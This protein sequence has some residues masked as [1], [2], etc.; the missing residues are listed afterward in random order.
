M[1]NK[2]LI[3]AGILLLINFSAC[4][5]KVENAEPSGWD[6]VETI[7]NQI[8]EPV[9]QDNNF[10]LLDFG[11]IGD[12][13]FD[14]IQAFHEIIEHCT[15]NG[16][17]K[18]IV[19]EGNYF[20]KGP[21]HLESNINLHLE[22]GARL[23]F[24]SDP[25]DY[26]PNVLTS[27]EGTRIYNYSPF[28][29]AINKKNII[30]SGKGEIDGEAAETWSAW[31]KIQNPDKLLSRKM[32]NTNV[33]LEDRIF[34]EGH[35]LR[36]HMVQFYEC[37]NILI[38][39]IIITDSPFWCIHVIFSKNI[40]VRKVRY[41]AQNPNNDGIDA[42]SCENVLI[43]NIEFS[44][45]DDNIAIKSGRD[46]EARTLKR[47]SKNIIIRNCNFKGLNSFAVGSEMS[48]GVNNIFIE[49][50]GFAGDVVYGIYL[51]GNKDR[52][53]IVENIYVRNI[54]FQNARSAILIDSNYKNE[55]E[56]HPPQFRNVFIENIV[57]ENAEEY[58]ISLI[59][60]EEKPLQNIN[61]KNV[62]VNNATSAFK[63]ENVGSLKV[64]NIQINGMDYTNNI[65]EDEQLQ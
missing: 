26:L 55:G 36:P 9:I 50:C 6:K 11:G 65:L 60:S 2:I 31:K 7:L 39:D 4:K 35:F 34:G 38:E 51:K 64:E 37:E 12:G 33:P 42:E 61:I 58:G 3:F 43:E 13:R 57:C 53:G 5:Q 16:G 29:Y 22:E 40:I 56:G 46:L 28:I 62:T 41:D 30:I 21:L 47:E 23:F 25:K 52:G 19:P 8:T 14:N 24:S 10:N 18:I 44:N 15:E 54:E 59:G 49:D 45:M 27:W 32:N 48:G 1:K 63:T 20:M 17:G